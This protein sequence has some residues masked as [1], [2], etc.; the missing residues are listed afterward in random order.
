MWSLWRRGKRKEEDRA[1]KALQDATRNLHEVKKR[2]HEV[3]KV[4]NALRAERERNG[5]AEALEAIITSNKG[6]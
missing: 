3:T 2:S 1:G 5:F 6:L 4:S